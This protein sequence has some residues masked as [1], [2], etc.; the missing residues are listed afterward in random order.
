[1]PGRLILVKHSHVDI[2]LSRKACPQ[3]EVVTGVA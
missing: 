1:M 2:V 3:V